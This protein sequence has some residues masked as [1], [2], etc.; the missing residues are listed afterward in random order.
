MEENFYFAGAARAHEFYRIARRHSIDAPTSVKFHMPEL[1]E[2]QTVVATLRPRL[3]GKR[4]E[5]ARIHR[6]DVIRPT[7]VDLA[8]LLKHRVISDITRRGKKILFH[9]GDGN[10]F[11]VHLGMSGRLMLQ[12]GDAPLAA[13]THVVLQTIVGEVRFVDPRRFGGIFWLGSESIADENL[14]PEPL[15]IRAA[16]LARRLS[17]TRRAIKNALLDQSVIAGLGN[18]YVDEALFEAGIHPLTL[19]DRLTRDQVAALTRSIKR[20]LNRA[21]KHR[22]STLRDYR[23]PDDNAGE[24]QKLHRV[25]HRAGKPC[26]KCKTPIESIRLGGRS[27]HF[28]PKCQKN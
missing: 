9:L 22:G 8:G 15:E 1:P 23:D 13:H 2:V 17:R 28:C 21:L 18:I 10:R 19:A 16:E 25:Y 24:F 27:T 20:V 12:T 5:F 4:I 7:S 26:Q 11:Y 3:L 6:A 14:G